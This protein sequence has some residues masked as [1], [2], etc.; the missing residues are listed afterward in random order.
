MAGQGE[1][2]ASG[3]VFHHF[4]LTVIMTIKHSKSP[5][6]NDSSKVIKV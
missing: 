2:S 3:K 6:Q 5:E 1:K 4:L